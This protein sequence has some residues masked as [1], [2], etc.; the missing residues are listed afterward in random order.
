MEF[1][2]EDMMQAIETLDGLQPCWYD[3]ILEHGPVGNEEYTILGDDVGSFVHA[4]YVLK[5]Y[6]KI[7][8]R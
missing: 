8:G 5:S 6:F 1:T 2:E 3:E 7:V 4:V